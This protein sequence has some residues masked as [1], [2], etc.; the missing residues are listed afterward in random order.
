MKK[1]IA[2]ILTVL[3]VGASAQLTYVTTLDNDYDWISPPMQVEIGNN[4]IDND[5]YLIGYGPENNVNKDRPRAYY[6]ILNSDFSLY[7]RI[8]IDTTGWWASG[9]RLRDIFFSDHL[10]NTDDKIEVIYSLK[11]SDNM[12]E[13]V[14]DSLQVPV[15]TIVMDEDGV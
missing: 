14:D 12:T 10:I 15:K 9:I 2:S 13:S 5:K 8:T 3:T 6:D 4:L 11:S 1:L 7:K